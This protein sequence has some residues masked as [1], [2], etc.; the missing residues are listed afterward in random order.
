MKKKNK[1]LKKF[2][3][4]RLKFLKESKRYI[5]SISLV[6]LFFALVG[7][8]FP[9]FFEDKIMELIKQ[10]LEKFIGLNLEQTI[11]MI[12][13][14]NLQASFFSMVFGIAFG[15][16]P[17]FSAVVNG[18]LVGFVAEKAVAEGGI[19]VLWRLFPHG[20]F[21]LPAVLISMGLGL[22]IGFEVFKKKAE[23]SLKRNLIESW[24][25]F[26]SVVLPLLVIAA[27]IEGTLVFLLG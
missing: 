24:K 9:V 15:I 27:I 26:Y 11:L 1:S 12:F 6:F 16:L 21:E 4:E 8:F 19:L 14:N 10:L 13:L 22:K 17:L 5:F 7:Y 18:Y 20:I 3:S 2:Y 25:L 23:K